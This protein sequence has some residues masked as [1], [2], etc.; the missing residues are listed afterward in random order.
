MLLNNDLTQQ[1]YRQQMIN[2]NHALI[3]KDRNG[4]RDVAKWFFLHD[5]ALSHTSKLAKDTMKSPLPKCLAQKKNSFS[6]K[7]FITYPKYGQSVYKQMANILNKRKMK[8]PWK[9]FVFF[10]FYHKNRH[11]VFHVRY[12]SSLL[13][14]SVMLLLIELLIR[15]GQRYICIKWK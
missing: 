11:L 13:I 12:F 2:L 8:F 15:E 10:F 6:G 14:V 3:E 7:V 5:N 9:L 4:P 1:C